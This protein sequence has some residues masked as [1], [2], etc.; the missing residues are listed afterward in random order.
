MRT[1]VDIADNLVRQAKAVAHRDRTTL[2]A[3]VE[4]G[5]HAVLTR[6]SKA[7]SVHIRPVIVHGRMTPEFHNATWSQLRDEFYRGRGA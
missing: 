2:R 7:M 6:R 1:T 4:E 3:L 5:L